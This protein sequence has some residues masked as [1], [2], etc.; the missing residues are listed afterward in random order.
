VGGKPIGVGVYADDDERAAALLA[1]EPRQRRVDGAALGA[2]RGLHV[3]RDARGAVEGPTDELK[4][5][6]GVVVG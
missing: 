1:L 4:L 5:V 6:G 3:A 2:R